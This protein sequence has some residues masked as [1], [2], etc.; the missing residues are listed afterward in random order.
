MP[1][2]DDLE[3]VQVDEQQEDPVPMAAGQRQRLFQ[4]VHEQAA[5]GQARQAVMLG[6][7]GQLVLLVAQLAQLS[8]HLRLQLVGCGPASPARRPGAA[9]DPSSRARRQS[10]G[11]RLP[12]H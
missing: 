1:V 3:I 9:A 10:R 2:V 7:V 12:S 4:P 8:P 5:V 11:Q 6:Q